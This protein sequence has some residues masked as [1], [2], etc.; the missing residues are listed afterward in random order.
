MVTICVVSQKGGVGKSTLSRMIAVE[1]A[2]HYRDTK[3][4]IADTDDRQS[5]CS[6][7]AQ[8]REERG[9][10]PSINVISYTNVRQAIDDAV[11]Y[12]FMIIDGTP[13]ASTDTLKIAQ[14]SHVVVIP[15]GNSQDDLDPSIKLAWELEDQGIPT[16]SIVFGLTRACDSSIENA[17]TIETLRQAGFRMADGYLPFRTAYIQA[18]DEG[19][20][21]T[22]SSHPT[23]RDRAKA[24]CHSLLHE[25]FESITS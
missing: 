3:I 12:D 6:V 5:T 20:A 14:A 2:T 7:W 17:R 23:L 15:C 18:G 10:E 16:K 11:N 4:G 19:L 25:L 22:E 8:R 24:F 9:M 13:N 21:V 1:F